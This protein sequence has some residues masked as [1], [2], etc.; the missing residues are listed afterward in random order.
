MQTV[1]NVWRRGDRSECHL[2]VTI[3]NLLDNAS[4]ARTGAQQPG[5][6]DRSV[7]E[8]TARAPGVPR[9]V[10]V[11]VQPGDV[12]EHG[13]ST[14]STRRDLK[15][16]S[17]AVLFLDLDGFKEINDTLGHSSG[18]ELLVQVAQRLSAPGAPG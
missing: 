16:G 4:V 2:E 17:L 9:L 5:R 11:A 18:D 12:Q 15:P 10:D 14:R 8:E 7:L 3:T 13:S 1:Q 6:H